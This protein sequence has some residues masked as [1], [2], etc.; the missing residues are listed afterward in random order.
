MLD[1]FH[2]MMTKGFGISSINRKPQ[3]DINTTYQTI[4]NI[5]GFIPK[6]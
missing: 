5:F 3:L 6:S 4:I 2:H 1:Y